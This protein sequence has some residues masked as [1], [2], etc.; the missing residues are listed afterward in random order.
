MRRI[1]H[2]QLSGQGLGPNL[3]AW[4][5]GV[6]VQALED[7]WIFLNIFVSQLFSPQRCQLNFSSQLLQLWKS[8]SVD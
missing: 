5:P 8:D 3:T 1:R 2:T 7:S 6:H 4:A